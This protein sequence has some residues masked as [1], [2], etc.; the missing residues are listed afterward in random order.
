MLPEMDGLTLVRALR[1][2]SDVPVLMLTARTGEID[3]IVGLESEPT[4]I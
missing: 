1:Q 2:E 4:I 3:K